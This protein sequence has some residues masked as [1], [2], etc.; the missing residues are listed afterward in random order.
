MICPIMSAGLIVRQDDFISC[1][2]EDCALWD[3]ERDCCGL[4]ALSPSEVQG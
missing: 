3:I 2:G 4:R 1:K